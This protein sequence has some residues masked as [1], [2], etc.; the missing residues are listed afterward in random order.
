MQVHWIHPEVFRDELRSAVEQR[1]ERLAAGHTDLID[2]R[3]AARTTPHHR[4]GNQEVRI[5]CQARGQEIVAA[6]TRLEAALALEEA[7]EAFEREV[8]ALRSRRN[9][10]RGRVE[11][12]PPE[13]GIVDRVFRDEGYGFILTDAG[14][15]VYFHR[16]ALHGGLAFDALVEGQRVGLDIEPGEEGV[17]ATV[18]RPAPPGAPAP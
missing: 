13:L 10:P 16:N 18:V 5:V 4:H 2:I 1:L 6:R 11:T 7:F 8:R 9:D 3:I 12:A 15:R 17:Q 14:D